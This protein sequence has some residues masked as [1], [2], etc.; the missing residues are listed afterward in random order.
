MKPEKISSFPKTLVLARSLPPAATGSGI[1]MTNLL[2]QFDCDEMVAVGAYFLNQ[3]KSRWELSWPDLIYG[4]LEFQKDWGKVWVR[5]IQWPLLFLTGLS[6]AVLQNCQTILVI[7]PDDL[8]L[9]AGYILC[10]ITNKPLYVYLHNTYLE[11]KP[12]NRFAQWLQANVFARARHVFVMSVGM[13]KFYQRKYPNLDC[14]PLVHTFNET[15]PEPHEVQEQDLHNPVNLVFIGNI[16]A[17]CADAANRVLRFV[18]Q[19]SSVTLRIYS[20]MNQEVLT[21][22]GFSGVNISSKTV[23]YDVLLEHMRDGDIMIHPHGFHG[24]LVQ[25]EFKTIFPTKTIEYL[26]SQRPILAHLPSDCYL[27]DFY[28]QHQCALLIHEPEIDALKAG[29]AQL[30]ADPEFRRRLVYNALVAVRQFRAPIVANHLRQVL[31]AQKSNIDW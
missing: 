20:G 2:R 13:Q 28:R 4:M 21:R 27:A 11:S 18:K 23:P 14:S 15:L 29:V 26:L 7:Y 9:L 25:T 10:R 6:T 12:N 17:S 16:T 24:T 31:S 22:L 5:R 1:V 3:P 19:E 30:V 8:F